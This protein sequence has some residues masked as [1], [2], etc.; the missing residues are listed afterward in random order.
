MS[1]GALC[2]EL[3]NTGAAIPAWWFPEGKGGHNAAH[4]KRAKAVCALCPS[5]Q[6]CLDEAM[7]VEAQAGVVRHGIF[8]GLT[9]AERYALADSGGLFE[10]VCEICDTPFRA[11]RL[12]KTCSPRCDQIRLA[13]YMRTYQR[14]Y[15]NN[16]KPNP[17]AAHGTVT[18]AQTGCRCAVCRNWRRQAQREARLRARLRGVAAS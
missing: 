7:A 17:I 11:D 6:A 18:M 4:K 9:A 12:R 3:V 2:A 1:E 14:T 8:G 5:R 13:R 10:R 16:G 15:R